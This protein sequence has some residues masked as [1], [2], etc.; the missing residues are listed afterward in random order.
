MHSLLGKWMEQ[1]LSFKTH[2]QIQCKSATFNLF[3]LCKTHSVFTRET[4]KLLALALIISHLD[5]TNAIPN[6]LPNC[7]IDKM[8]RIQNMAVKMVLGAP[9]YSSP[10]ECMKELHWLPI[11]FRIQHKILTM[12]YKTLHGDVQDYMKSMLSEHILSIGGLKSEQSYIMLCIPHT[13]RKTFVARS[14]SVAGPTYWNALPQDVKK[15]E[16]VATS[17]QTLKTNLFKMA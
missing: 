7:D 5:Y 2:I 11:W 8:Q 4:A 10:M 16:N 3:R 12:V 9:K 13:P 17:K 15:S 14:F 1:C 6:G